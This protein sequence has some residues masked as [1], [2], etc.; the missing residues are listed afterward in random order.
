MK[1]DDKG[2]PDN[3]SKLRQK[4]EKKMGHL[5]LN[6][7]L[8]EMSSEDML[9]LIHELQ[10][11]QIEL[12][13]QNE[14]LR[15]V[16]QELDQ[17]RRKYYDLYDFAPVGYLIVSEE[18]IIQKANLT[19]VKM[20]GLEKS[21]LIGKPFSSFVTK[22]DHDKFYQHRKDVFAEEDPQ[23]CELRLVR[24]NNTEFYAQLE[25]IVIENND[26]GHNQYRTVLTNITTR[27]HAQNAHQESDKRL[28]A[29]LENAS[30]T[31]SYM[32]TDLK[33]TWVYNT[34]PDF[35]PEKTL[36]KRIDEIIPGPVGEKMLLIYQRV[37]ET[38][39]GEKFEQQ[40]DLTTGTEIYDVTIE[41]LRD[42]SGNIT[43]LTTIAINLTEFRLAEEKLDDLERKY[44]HLFKLTPDGV[45]TI[46]NVGII[47][48]I[49][50]AGTKILGYEKAEKL[51]GKSVE[52]LYIN[53]ADL[54]SILEILANKDLYENYEVKAKKKD[55]SPVYLI[56]S[57]AVDRGEDGNI[58]T[59][60][61][62]FKNI[63]QQKLAMSEL[64]KDRN[65]LVGM[66]DE[67]T[68]DLAEVNKKLQRSYDIQKAVN[69]LMEMSLKDTSLEDILNHALDIIFSTPWLSSK[70]QAVIFL[71]EEDSDNLV[72]TAHSGI[73]E[74]HQQTCKRIPFGKCVCGRA[75]LEQ[76]TLFSDGTENLHEIKYENFKSHGFYVVPIISYDRVI[77]V[78]K[79]NLKDG[80][81]YNKKEEEFLESIAKILAGIIERKQMED[82]LAEERKSLAQRVQHQTSKL[83]EVNMDLAK[84]D[85]MKDEFLAAMSH[86]LRTPI[87][88]ILGMAEVLKFSVYGQL[89]EEQTDS[90][91]AIE[92]SGQHLL[93]LINDILDVSKIEVGQVNLELKH[94][95]VKQVCKAS[96][97]FVERDARM[98]KLKLSSSFDSTVTFILADERR[99]KQILV[100][101]LSNAVKFTPEGGSVGLEVVGDSEGEKVDFTVWDTGIG[102]PEDQIPKLFEP[103]VQ[104]DSKLSRRHRG[105]GLGLALVKQLVH[106]HN[107]SISVESKKA[108]GSRFSFSLPWRTAIQNIEP[109]E[110]K[111]DTSEPATANLASLMKISNPTGKPPA[112][113]LVEDNE[114]S[115]K[116]ISAY[117]SASDAQII[118][119]TDG[120]EAIQL[121]REKKPDLILMDIQMPGMDGL[122]A[123]RIIREDPHIND[124]PIIALTAL[125]MPGDRAKCLE[126]GANDYIS[127]P[128]GMKNL[129]K[130][131]RKQL[132]DQN[133]SS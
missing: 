126:A 122:E 64:Q 103:F 56:S 23:T 7:N 92:E 124:T 93:S 14:E 102:I 12:E 84:A 119:A 132:S 19:S 76:K 44:T 39:I 77:G 55:G 101:L 112:I 125:A 133:T 85:R 38:G 107:G 129:V 27:R 45:I 65:H 71:T 131:I 109:D 83:R 67:R 6:K 32:D 61:A 99:L 114:I 2:N 41:P 16:Q 50:P 40:F 87:S 35:V 48:S 52:E 104:L 106:M 78:M 28:H 25:S 9:D 57:V 100:N 113:L 70:P 42:A 89:N 82:E 34:H 117:L 54:Q 116:S 58:L 123:I 79:L 36:G 63:T 69:S 29:V 20:L 21:F 53:P 30:I 68:S 13:M 115:I 43:G 22:H 98:K 17:S 110:T 33:Y 108:K 90:V 86:E 46:S 8:D 120:K 73:S 121:V 26:E 95:P 128:V 59:F 105:T 1:K 3:Y 49:N 15:R 97:R 60:E 94:I 130:S 18:G 81:K 111:S 96:L 75:A 66:V 31:A 72:L 80:Q 91:T 62:I 118:I 127:K 5:R 47:K 10:V 24:N 37:L 88:G 4:A 74:K 51:V 11:H